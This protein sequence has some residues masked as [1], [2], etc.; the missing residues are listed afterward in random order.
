MFDH[1]KT[2]E[3]LEEDYNH[4]R[5]IKERLLNALLQY[6]KQLRA[7][8]LRHADDDKFIRKQL[9]EKIDETKLHILHIDDTMRKTEY[10]IK[11]LTAIKQG[12]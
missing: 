11:F 8:D 4:A 9:I 5:M 7:I 12:R 2:I 6:E 3:E 10:M 1:D